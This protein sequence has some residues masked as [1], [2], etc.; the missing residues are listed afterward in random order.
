M[1]QFHKYSLHEIEDMI[2][3]E[4]QIYIALLSGHIE[5]ENQKIQERNNSRR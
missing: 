4:R 2:P 5:E 3:W 1:V